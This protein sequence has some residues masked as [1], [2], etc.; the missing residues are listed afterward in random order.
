MEYLDK[1]TATFKKDFAKEAIEWMSLSN[2][3]PCDS[4]VSFDSVLK[5]AQVFCPEIANKEELFDQVVELN[6]TIIRVKQNDSSRFANLSV[7]QR[8]QLLLLNKNVNYIARLVDTVF[9]IPCSNAFCERLFSLMNIQW[10]DERNSLDFSTVASILSVILNSNDIKCH[11]FVEF[12]LEE[13]DIERLLK[14]S[15]KYLL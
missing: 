6:E 8:W 1:W 9:S 14:S 3:E 4:A 7:P 15:E 2:H 12:L 13:K 5:T 11:D 10:T